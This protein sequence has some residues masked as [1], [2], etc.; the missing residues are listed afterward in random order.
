MVNFPF[1]E[2]LKKAAQF[3]WSYKWLWLLGLFIVG[4][5]DYNFLGFLFRHSSLQN[6]NWRD[7]QAAGQLKIFIVNNL[8]AVWWG[9]AALLVLTVF[10][11]YL[12][13]LARASAIWTAGQNGEDLS[14]SLRKALKQG[15]GKAWPLAGL[16]L[17][18]LLLIMAGIFIIMAPIFYLYGQGL[19]ARALW[20]ATLGLAV[21]LPFYIIVSFAMRYAANFVVLGNMPLRQAIYA[22]LALFGRFWIVSVLQAVLTMLIYALAIMAFVFAVGV[23]G[24]FFRGLIY[25]AHLVFSASLNDFSNYAGA[26]I[27]AL[28]GISF[29]AMVSV[30]QTAVW[31]KTWL[32]LVKRQKLEQRLATEKINTLPESYPGV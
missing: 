30:W 9:L 6:F 13:G 7:A 27:L 14:L 15:R 12:N 20:L 17:I 29:G 16:N 32:E 21:F 8:T 2:I 28:V 23:G 10:F 22:G 26:I 25:L 11:F 24:L 18:Y 1:Q 19:S 3:T 31:T 5:G 4:P